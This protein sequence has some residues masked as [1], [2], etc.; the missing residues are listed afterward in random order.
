MDA[1]AIVRE[2]HDEE[3]SKDYQDEYLIWLCRRY[4]KLVEQ[5]HKR[6]DAGV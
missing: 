3:L 4:I 5:R 6:E 1:I 2:F